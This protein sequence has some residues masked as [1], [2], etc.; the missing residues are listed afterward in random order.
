MGALLRQGHTARPYALDERMIAAGAFL[1]AA[2]ER[3]KDVRPETMQ[4]SEAD[5][6]YQASVG[7]LERALRYQVDWVL[8]VSGMYLH[9]DALVL[10]RRAGRRV[11]LICTESPYEQDKELRLAG[12][13]SAVWTNERTSVNAF[14]A[15]CP[16]AY[17]WQHAIDPERHVAGT[18]AGDEDVAAHDVVFVGTG[19]E[20]RIAW[21]EAV[22]WT[23]IDLGLYGSWEMLT[24]DSP[25]QPYVRGGVTDNATTAALYRRAKIGLNLHRTTKGW[26][27]G[28]E[29]IA[30]AEAESL[31][32]R[33]YELAAA[34]CFF[35]S[36]WRE[37]LGDVFGEIAARVD[38]PADM[39]RAMRY[40][41]EHEG[42]RERRA[43]ALPEQV[44]AHTFDNRVRE[45][46]AQLAR[47]QE[48]SDGTL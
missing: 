44:A 17:Y 22:D 41:L 12:V 16:N 7:I 11:A 26:G 15:V 31:G 13:C 42:E 23:G 37:E 8:V 9:P 4:P 3:A 24:D 33:C 14:R 28:A 47:I 43:A 34:G 46:V 19:F 39:T 1:R 18:Q 30:A 20:E 27:M 25:L 29:H 48:A 35:L 40:W 6:I 21:L 10:M 38:T 5:V 2:Y 45:M 36:D 32:P